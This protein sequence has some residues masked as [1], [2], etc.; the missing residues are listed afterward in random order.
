MLFPGGKSPSLQTLNRCGT[1]PGFGGD[2][3]RQG[4]SSQ[5]SAGLLPD[6]Q[7]SETKPSVFTG[8]TFRLKNYLNVCFLVQSSH[9]YPHFE[10]V[11]DERHAVLEQRREAE[12]CERFLP[13]VHSQVSVP[14]AQQH[15]LHAQQYTCPHTGVGSE[16]AAQLPLQ[17]SLPAWQSGLNSEVT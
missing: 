4:W 13:S 3:S 10:L 14:Q 9:L 6:P 7:H 2:T 17:H 1:F 8:S 11:G 16:E 5:G 15:V 12:V